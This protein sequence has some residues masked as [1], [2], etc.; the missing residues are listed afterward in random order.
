MPQTPPDSDLIRRWLEGTLR[1]EDESQLESLGEIKEWVDAAGNLDTAPLRSKEA[2]WEALDR[3]MNEAEMPVAR[4]RTL[5]RPVLVALAAAVVALLVAVYLFRP[6]APHT[7]HAAS[8]QQINQNLPDG[9]S[10][11]LNAQSTL[12]F[13]PDHWDQARG[14]LLEGEAYFTVR[15]G[16]TFLVK[17]SGADIRVLGTEFNV[18]A[19]DQRIDVACF[20]G[21]VEVSAAGERLLLNPGDAAQTAEN[22]RLE[23]YAFDKEGKAAWKKGEFYFDKVAL[24]FVIEELERQ[25]NVVVLMPSNTERIYTGFFTNQDLPAALEMVCLPMGLNYTFEDKTRIRLSE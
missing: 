11:I 12:S 7:I 8:G 21:K 22:G 1:E 3:R 10:V 16:S 25:F 4:T 5:R 17:T 24:K 23:A 19:R 15:P 20:T 2:A 14:I 13:D 9:S 18:F 6:D